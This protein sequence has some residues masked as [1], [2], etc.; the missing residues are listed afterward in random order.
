MVVTGEAEADTGETREVEASGGQWTRGLAG[1]AV[2]EILA[3]SEE[4][5]LWARPD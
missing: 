4:V 2:S 5:L 3:S 1:L